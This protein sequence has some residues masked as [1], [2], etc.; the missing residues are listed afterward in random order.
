[1]RKLNANQIYMGLAIAALVL[2]LFLPQWTMLIFSWNGISALFGGNHITE[3]SA[4]PLIGGWVSVLALGAGIYFSI[5]NKT[6]KTITQQMFLCTCVACVGYILA[7]V[8]CIKSESSDF[9]SVSFHPSWVSFVLEVI[10]LG[11]LVYVPKFL[12]ANEEKWNSLMDK[13]GQK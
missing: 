4:L 12:M 2:F 10:V 13:M 7:T 6:A 3:V 11:A 9:I 1:M 5:Q 8:C